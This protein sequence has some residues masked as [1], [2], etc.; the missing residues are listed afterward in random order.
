MI[1]IGQHHDARNELSRFAISS[2]VRPLS[3]GKPDIEDQQVGL[4]S[5]NK[6]SPSGTSSGLS[7]DFDAAQ[8]GQRRRHAFADHGRIIHQHH[9]I[10]PAPECVLPD[11]PS[12]EAC[13]S[14]NSAFR[15]NFRHFEFPG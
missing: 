5:R 1:L 4:V 6:R 8:C 7:D 13:G 3:P 11:S 9:A 15:R 2:R 14:A 10:G 12:C